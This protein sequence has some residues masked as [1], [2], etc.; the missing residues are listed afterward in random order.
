M[1]KYHSIDNFNPMQRSRL[2]GEDRSKDSGKME[3][4]H[5]VDQ[6]IQMLEAIGFQ[7]TTDGGH[8]SAYRSQLN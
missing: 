5:H 3:A 8:G 6:D 2:R 7:S 4:R 1:Q